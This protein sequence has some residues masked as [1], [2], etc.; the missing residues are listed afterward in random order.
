MGELYRTARWPVWAC[1]IAVLSSML[2]AA[3]PVQAQAS[4]QWAKALESTWNG[5]KQRFIYCGDRCAQTQGLVHDPSAGYTAVSEGV[6]YGLLMAVTMNDQRAFDDVLAAADR[7]LLEPNTGLYNWKVDSSG[8]VIGAGAA[9]DADQDIALALIFAEQRVKA[10]DW[11]PPADTTYGTRAGDL[12]DAIYRYMVYQDK[13]L[14]PGD[15]WAGNGVEITNPSYFAPA[16]YRIFDKFQGTNR[17][18]SVIDQLYTSLNA[19]QGAPLGLAPDWMTADGKP[20]LD[21]CQTINRPAQDC[22]YAMTYDAIRVPWRIGLDCLWFGEARAC[23]WSKRTAA[24]LSK[25]R[26]PAYDAKM[27][28]MDGKPVS[29]FQDEAMISMWLTAAVAAKDESLKSRLAARLPAF[30][31]FA[32]KDGY[33]GAKAD[34]AG[35]YYNQSLMWF[36]VAIYAD[37]FKNRYM[38]ATAK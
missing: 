20:A 16:W 27:F 33:W 37:Q 38:D 26:S 29:A 21:F 13:Y 18:Q 28:A 11:Q 1:L 14:T 10:G 25:L 8:K 3:Q 19:S 17:W 36:G 30:A 5:Y 6:G 2:G 15:Q 32:A 7:I 9:T 12:I 23:D 24:F 35:M 4:G 34:R 22:K 31:I